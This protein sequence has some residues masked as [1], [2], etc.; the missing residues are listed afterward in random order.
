MDNRLLYDWLT[1]SF[2]SLDYDVLL[3]A[4]GLH[5]LAWAEQD[6]GSR[7]RYGH[8]LAFDGISV[9]YTDDWDIRHNAGCC[10]EMSGQGCRD[11]ESYGTGDWVD[12]WRFV[13][14]CQGKVTRL[15]I[16][17]DDFSGVLPL[18]IIAD[19]AARYLFTARSQHLRI[20][21]ESV[22]SDPD[23]MGISVC[24][25]TKSSDIY[26]RI[27]DKRVERKRWDLPYWVRCEIQL[28]GDNC[29]G[30]VGAESGLG[31]KYAGVLRNYLQYRCPGTDSNLRRHPVAPFW[32]KFLGAAA[33]LQINTRCDVE[34]NK[35][36]LDA[37]VY[38]RN[39]NAIRTA[40]I[41]DGLPE[42][43]RRT[44]ADQ[45][46]LPSKYQDI[47]CTAAASDNSDA[48]LR[49]LGETTEVQLCE[50]AQQSMAWADAHA[51]NKT[52]SL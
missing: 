31:D 5:H 35:Q 33:A 21:H 47:I 40:I 39:H 42:F 41:T 51:V 13:R 46:E 34:Y 27:Y 38:D 32:D 1:V 10:L 18:P 15:D 44:F 43:L 9:H 45:Q 23:H 25:G 7:L 3:R 24:H 49:I 2:R 30:F 19:M 6:T 8:R 11:F 29:A 48:I 22:D 50:L 28:R 36:R 12:L 16:A 20:M 14:G 37:H 26:I 17:Y 4:L 52:R